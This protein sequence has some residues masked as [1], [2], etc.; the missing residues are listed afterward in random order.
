MWCLSDLM[1]LESSEAPRKRYKRTG[2]QWYH[3]QRLAPLM[4]VRLPKSCVSFQ[5]VVSSGQG[6]GCVYNA[7]DRQPC[8]RLII[9]SMP[10]ISSIENP[11]IPLQYAACAVVKNFKLPGLTTAYL[12]EDGFE[13][14]RWK[15]QNR[16]SV[17]SE[18]QTYS[19][20]YT[21]WCPATSTSNERQVVTAADGS[22]I[23]P[24]IQRYIQ[25]EIQSNANGQLSDYHLLALRVVHRRAG[26][27]AGHDD[28]APERVVPVDLHSTVVPSETP[29]S[30]PNQHGVIS[31]GNP[32]AQPIPE[33]CWHKVW[34]DYGSS[35]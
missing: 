23:P 11:Y 34:L 27:T 7:G 31:N 6:T 19:L 29:S 13:G 17:R 12:V 21:P 26:G 4:L 35:V 18:D 8:C 15:W 28:S 30:Q 10:A 5:P 32:L 3:C 16:V 25:Q 2:G 1:G 9:H 22:V 24:S 20:R 14:S 33:S